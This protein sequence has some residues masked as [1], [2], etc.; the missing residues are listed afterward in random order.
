[1]YSAVGIVETADRQAVAQF[2][3]EIEHS[4]HEKTSDVGVNVDSGTPIKGQQ[5][6][7]HLIGSNE[8]SCATLGIHRKAFFPSN[9]QF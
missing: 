9:R 5:C 2:S 6:R 3:A 4:V 7:K 1:M 8:S